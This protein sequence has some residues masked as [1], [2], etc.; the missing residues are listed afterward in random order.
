MTSN[1]DVLT[2]HFG[3]LRSPLTTRVDPF[4]ITPGH[5][6]RFGR[7]LDSSRPGGIP[8]P[9]SLVEKPPDCAEAE[10]PTDGARIVPTTN[11]ARGVS[12]TAKI[13]PTSPADRFR[14][15]L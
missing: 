7:A 4:P 1:L 11:R 2:V 15:A 9:R 5:D 13:E 14:L 3:P 12:R 8:R 6:V 10:G